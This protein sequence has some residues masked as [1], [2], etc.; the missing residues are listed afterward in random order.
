MRR[1]GM[2]VAFNATATGI[3]PEGL[4]YVQDGEERLIEADTVV[5]ATGQAP[6]WEEAT[7]FAPCAPQFQMIGDCSS[8]ANV[9]T[10]VRNAYTIARDL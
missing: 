10:A 2:E 1:R 5:V 6:L 7:A 9:M 4:R 3:G 8:V